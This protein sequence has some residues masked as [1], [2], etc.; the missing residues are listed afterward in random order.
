MP[1]PNER[2]RR[3][4]GSPLLRDMVAEVEVR[5]QNLMLPLFVTDTGDDQPIA[6]MDGVLRRSPESAAL[7]IE[8]C[9]ERGLRAFIL[10]GVPDH[11]D[12]HAT[13]AFAAGGIVQRALRTV[14][15]R[16]GDAVL[17]ATDVCACAY[18]DH[19]HCGLLRDSG[20]DND[21]SCSLMARIALSHVEAGADMVAPSDMMDGRVRAIRHELDSQGYATV[22]ILSYAVKYASTLYGPFRNAAGSAPGHGDRR[23]YQMDFRDGRAALREA[24]LD[25]EEGAD[26]L[27]VKPGLAYL[28]IL[29]RLSDAVDV[30]LAAYQVSGEYA[31]LRYAAQ[32]GALDEAQAVRETWTAFRRAG[33]DLILS[34]HAA[35]AALQ[36]WL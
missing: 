20:V 13:S 26:I 30:P 17:L 24:R 2:P 33:A 15:D 23:G 27:M 7:Q 16:L 10:F 6:G 1:F 4:R 25:V 3:L 9:A 31:M 11:K 12:A 18:T 22:P 36:G 19:G 8:A 29:T 28:D 14:R 35:P 5:M 34:Y 21:A 32:A